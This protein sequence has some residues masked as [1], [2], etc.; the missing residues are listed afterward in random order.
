M[1][2]FVFGPV[3]SRRLGLSLGVDI[4]PRKYC[5]FDCIYCQLGKTTNKEIKRT[6]FFD[7]ELVI[8]EIE[9][10]LKSG[11]RTDFITFSGS[12][13]PTLNAD[14]GW[15][16]RKVK[17]ITSVPIAVITNGSLFYDEQVREELMVADLVLPS[18]DAVSEDIFRYLNRP[19]IHIELTQII[20]G[21]R[22]FTQEYKGR[23]WLEIMMVKH[24]ND[25]LEELEKFKKVVE[26]LKIDKIHLNT[27]KRPPAEEF[28]EGLEAEDLKRIREF[29]GERCEVIGK[30]GSSITSEPTDGWE[31]KIVEVLR[32]RPLTVEDVS[33][34]TGIPIG[35][36]KAH[37]KAME[38]RGTVQRFCL[39]NTVYYS[40]RD[41]R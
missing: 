23:V 1:A 19:H 29:L 39:E 15:L 32:R 11:V 28:V 27:V 41:R 12:G 13:E 8:Y 7:R 4:I 33:I 26:T 18:L 40:F 25:D 2:E 5:T 6:S 10:T 36:A 38:K 37:L 35:K 30:C 17:A 14:L 16:L 22:S 31:E 34:I 20:E 3:P 24:V 9:S 21:L